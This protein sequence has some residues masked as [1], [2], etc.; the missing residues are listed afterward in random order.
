[1]AGGFGVLAAAIFAYQHW[2][3]VVIEREAQEVAA[4]N[5]AQQL[6]LAKQERSTVVLPWEITP[7]ASA[8]VATCTAAIGD[9][10]LSVGGWILRE[11]LCDLTRAVATYERPEK[12]TT[13]AVFVDVASAAFGQT[14]TVIAEGSAASV[15]RSLAFAPHGPEELPPMGA[16][17]ATARSHLQ[18]L[19][20]IADGLLQDPPAPDVLPGNE[21]PPPPDYLHRQITVTTGLS[22]DRLI[23]GLPTAGLRITEL[24][25]VLDA[26]AG[27]LTWNITG[28]IYGR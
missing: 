10:P 21:P 9:L 3:S 24:H 1:M 14:P 13:V 12:G 23:E 26:D 20:G 19:E 6:E 25:V 27:A 18:K 5:L 22:P 7:P 2:R 28:D 4:L 11:A 8:F 17:L 15:F 16:S